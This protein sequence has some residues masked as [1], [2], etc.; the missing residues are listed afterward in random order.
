MF[1]E[2][3]FET[4]RFKINY[5]LYKPEGSGDNMPLIVSL[6]GAGER[7]D[8]LNKI[9]RHALPRYIKEGEEF[10]AVVLMPQCPGRVV[11]NNVVFEIKALIDKIVKEY[12][13]DVHRVSVTGQSMGGCGT[14]EM[15]MTFSNFFSCIA[16][17]CGVNFSWRA[18]N[19]KNMPIWA[20]HGDADGIVPVRNSIELVDAIKRT[21]GNPRLTI[22]HG[23]GHEGWDFIYHETDVINWL[24]SNK[25]EDFSEQKEAF[26]EF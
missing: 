11:W 7:G 19:L 23:V 12:N 6:H 3:V 8:D 24:I 15:G 4:E 26:D 10:P 5:A 25:R 1:K 21:G 20:F 16:P 13:I 2:S 17:I 18:E 9:Y 14:W 22:M